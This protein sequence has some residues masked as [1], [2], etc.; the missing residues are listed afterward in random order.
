[1]NI[2]EEI[3]KYLSPSVTLQGDLTLSQISEYL[4]DLILEDI[5]DLAQK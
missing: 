3:E 2:M 1:M 5:N 4:N